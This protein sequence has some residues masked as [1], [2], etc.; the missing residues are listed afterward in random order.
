[1][2]TE[3]WSVSVEAALRELAAKEGICI[4]A[5]HDVG[6]DD[7]TAAAAVA[8]MATRPNKTPV[9]SGGTVIISLVLRMK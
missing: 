4:V 2:S 8:A 5:T 3:A 6:P 7:V 1:M 9:V